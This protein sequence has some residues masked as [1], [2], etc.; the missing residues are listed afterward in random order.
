MEHAFNPSTPEV[1]RETDL[2]SRLL[3][4]IVRSRTARPIY[5]DYVSE[6]NRKKGR[7]EKRKGGGGRKRKERRKR[8]KRRRRKRK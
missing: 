2:S 1:E 3:I 6:T 8:K 7:K 5:R 4:Y